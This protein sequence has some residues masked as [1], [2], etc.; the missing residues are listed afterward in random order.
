MSH[1][2]YISHCLELSVLPLTV[3]IENG[4]AFGS[5]RIMKLKNFGSCVKRF[6]NDKNVEFRIA[7][8]ERKS[9]MAQQIRGWGGGASWSF[10]DPNIECVHYILILTFTRL[11]YVWII[12]RL[13]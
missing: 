13:S 4:Y 6:L 12:A 8:V 11:T 1:I 2:H 9:K 3:V 5:Q 10:D 7:M